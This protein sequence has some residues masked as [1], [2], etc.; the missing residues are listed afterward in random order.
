[1]IDPSP[2][3]ASPSPVA[4]S[5]RERTRRAVQ[6]EVGE[7]AIGLFVDQGFEQTTIDQIAAAAGL[8][9]SSFFRHFGTK[10][11]AVLGHWQNRGQVVLDALADRPGAEPIWTS[12]QHAFEPLIASYTRDPA[13]ALTVA[14]LIADVPTLRACRTEKQVHWQGL[15][16]PE[17]AR[18][19]G[20]PGEAGDPRAAALTA[21]AL[22]CLDAAVTAWVETDGAVTLPV[23]LDEAMRAVGP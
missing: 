6:A 9:R 7:V 17:V 23:A 8:S 16:V 4:E 19:L 5:L 3:T 10:E 14:R 13:R 15:L 2:T 22:A 18:R 20:V 1:M 12:L 21:A 11:D